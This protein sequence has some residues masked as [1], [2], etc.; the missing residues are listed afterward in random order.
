M[1]PSP[2]RGGGR[3]DV[4]A[5]LSG[6]SPWT[7]IYRPYG[8][9]HDSCREPL[10]APGH[11]IVVV[12]CCTAFPSTVCRRFWSHGKEHDNGLSFCSRLGA[13]VR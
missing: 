6:L 1:N 8:C 4:A 5:A 9:W 10:L 13:L 11:R 7:T 3:K 2:A 12:S